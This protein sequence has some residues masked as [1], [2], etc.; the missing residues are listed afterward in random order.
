MTWGAQIRACD[1]C[2][3]VQQAPA[4]QRSHGPA[5]GVTGRHRP[6]PQTVK[7]ALP[8]SMPEYGIY[9]FMTSLQLDKVITGRCRI[10]ASRAW[11]YVHMH[12]TAHSRLY[13]LTFLRLGCADAQEI[14]HR[15]TEGQAAISLAHFIKHR[16]STGHCV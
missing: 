11:A 6:Y 5:A 3:P 12:A 10:T 8:I 16:E 1:V 13:A 15:I 9:P 7:L 2:K 4:R 14:S